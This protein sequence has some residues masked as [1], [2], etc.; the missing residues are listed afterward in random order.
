MYIKAVAHIQFSQMLGAIIIFV[1]LWIS[2]SALLFHA[3]QHFSL[4]LGAMQS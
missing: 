1:L 2:S 3:W 4:E